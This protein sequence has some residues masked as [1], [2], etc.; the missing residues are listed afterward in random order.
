MRLRTGR[1]SLA[2]IVLLVGCENGRP[3]A[4]P[5]PS[6]TPRSWSCRVSLQEY[7]GG[8]CPSYGQSI[9]ELRAY[10]AR[11][12]DVRFR[13]YP[14][15]TGHCP[16]LFFS[17]RKEEGM[18]GSTIRYFD[19]SGTMIGVVQGSDTTEFCN[20]SAFVIRAGIEMTCP[21]PLVQEVICPL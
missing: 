6:P 12:A 17:T 9:D 18:I 19:G 15:T 1:R 4:V 16:G 20:S 13:P 8:P 21:V 2:T 14:Q 10:C 11:A 5:S 3:T 7:C